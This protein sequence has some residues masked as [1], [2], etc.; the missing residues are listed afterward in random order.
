M[1]E[2]SKDPFRWQ[3]Q[4]FK[5]LARPRSLLDLFDCLPGVYM[6]IKDA[7]SRFVRANRV[8]CEVVGAVNPDELIG[9]TDFDFFPPA[10]ASQYIA[11]DQRVI[12]SGQPLTD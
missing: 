11:E 10:V 4:F 8:V 5:Q 1:T 7:E 9:R 6:Y 3:D 2:I 12:E